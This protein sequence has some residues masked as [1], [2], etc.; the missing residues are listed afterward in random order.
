MD[1]WQVWTS[2]L[3]FRE[4]KG[5]EGQGVTERQRKRWC[6]LCSAAN[7][8]WQTKRQREE[9]VDRWW[10]RQKGC[11]FLHCSIHEGFLH[12]MAWTERKTEKK[13]KLR[14]VTILNDRKKLDSAQDLHTICKGKTLWDP[15]VIWSQTASHQKPVLFF[16]GGHTGVY[17]RK[18]VWVIRCRVDWVV[19]CVR[20]IIITKR[21]SIQNKKMT[22][23]FIMCHSS[24]WGF[25][26]SW[27]ICVYHRHF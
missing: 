3:W 8:R 27:Y 15:L 18:C 25:H 16:D 11:V 19:L 12:W 6:H 4:K 1:I 26:F 22:Y 17:V 23:V 20:L 2:P 21:I 14:R 13:H 9:R 24:S 7:Q 10:K 5:R